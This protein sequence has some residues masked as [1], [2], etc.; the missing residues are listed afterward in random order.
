[1]WSIL[2][3]TPGNIGGGGPGVKFGGSGNEFYNGRFGPKIGGQ[4]GLGQATKESEGAVLAAL[5]WL[6]DHQSSDGSWK[7]PRNSHATSG[8]ALLAF[9]AHG[10]TADSKDFGDA[11]GRGLGISCPFD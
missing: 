8:L 10:E 3:E 11:V 7:C 5:R 2:S 9:F 6:R 1:M 4:P